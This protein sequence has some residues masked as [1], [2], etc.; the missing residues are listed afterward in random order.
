MNILD[1]VGGFFHSI[2]DFLLAIYYLIVQVGSLLKSGILSPV[3]Y[4]HAFTS[5]ITD[6]LS[7]AGITAHYNAI[8]AT[9]HFTNFLNSLSGI[10]AYLNA[11]PAWSV[12]EAAI[13]FIFPA[14]VAVWL[15]KTITQ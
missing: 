6:T 11:I 12:L 4:I 8:I 3:Y 15:F 2:F 1:L 13:A 7:T 10:N 9:G 5:G 14:L